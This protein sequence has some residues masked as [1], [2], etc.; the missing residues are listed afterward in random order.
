MG[1]KKGTVLNSA[2]IH[3]YV[4]LELSVK[5]KMGREAGDGGDRMGEY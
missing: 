4:R 3:I 1:E 5:I 2:R